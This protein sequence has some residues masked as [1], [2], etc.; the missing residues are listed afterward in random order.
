MMLTQ[1]RVT[2]ER[3]TSSLTLARMTAV[4]SGGH[5]GEQH[6]AAVA[7]DHR[8]PFAAQRA[9]YLGRRSRTV[10]SSPMTWSSAV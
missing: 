5:H 7:V 9:A 1:A 6:P 10:E 2:P 4:S 8:H 3:R